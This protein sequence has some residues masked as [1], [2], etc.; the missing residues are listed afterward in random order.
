MSGKQR[1]ADCFGRTTSCLDYILHVRII[2]EYPSHALRKHCA[3]LIVM[4]RRKDSSC[5]TF[6]LLRLSEDLT[7]LL[8]FLQ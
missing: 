4:Q 2:L 3:M 7:P 6:S 1:H 8:P 5:Q